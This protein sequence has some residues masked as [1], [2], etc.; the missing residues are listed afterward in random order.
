MTSNECYEFLLL[1]NRSI[2]KRY[3]NIAYTLMKGFVVGIRGNEGVL[4]L[5]YSGNDHFLKDG[6]TLEL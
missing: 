6:L 5:L 3:N 4:G 2:K 1:R